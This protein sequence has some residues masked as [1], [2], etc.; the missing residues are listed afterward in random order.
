[1]LQLVVIKDLLVSSYCTLREADI[2]ISKVS[3]IWPV[4]RKDP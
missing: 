4:K 1:M 2:E 3:D